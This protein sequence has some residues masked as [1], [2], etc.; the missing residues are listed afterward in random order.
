MNFLKNQF[1][2]NFSKNI[3]NRE[4]N[5]ILSCV[6]TVYLDLCYF[7]GWKGL[8]LIIVG[9]SEFFYILALN[10]KKK[11][12]IEV[13]MPIPSNSRIKVPGILRLFVYLKKKKNFMKWLNLAFIEDDG[14]VTYYRLVSDF[15]K[16]YGPMIR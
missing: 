12:Q 9:K 13:F 11:K 16:T 2:R 6:L 5:K 4:K 8:R 14:T 10:P 1:S 3:N 7:R 15:N